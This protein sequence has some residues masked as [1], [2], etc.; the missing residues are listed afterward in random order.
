MFHVIN[1]SKQKSRY[2]RKLS[3]SFLLYLG[4][5]LSSKG[6]NTTI[7]SKV[8]RESNDSNGNRNEENEE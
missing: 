2:S 8:T 4:I 1:V 3:F 7:Y 6:R 5:Y